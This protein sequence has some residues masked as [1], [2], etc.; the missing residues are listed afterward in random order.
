MKTSEKEFK[1]LIASLIALFVIGLLNR[2]VYAAWSMEKTGQIFWYNLDLWQQYFTWLPGKAF[3]ITL[4]L[5]VIVLILEMMYF[6]FHLGKK[7]EKH[8]NH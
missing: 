8:E 3:V 4:V 1:I 6:V 5:L 2:S 7:S